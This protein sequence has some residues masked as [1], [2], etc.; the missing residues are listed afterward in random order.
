MT[1]YRV[2]RAWRASESSIV[3]VYSINIAV[4]DHA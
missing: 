2:E 4:T 1:L 3:R